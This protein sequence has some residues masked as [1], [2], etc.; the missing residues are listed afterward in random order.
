MCAWRAHLGPPLL[1]HMLGAVKPHTAVTHANIL[2]LVQVHMYIL[3]MYTFIRYTYPRRRQSAAWCR[4]APQW[5]WTVQQCR[6]QT[7]ARHCLRLAQ[8]QQLLRMV[9]SGVVLLHAMC[10]CSM[11]HSSTVVFLW[12]FP[13]SIQLPRTML[14]S[15]TIPAIPLHA[16]HTSRISTLYHM[17]THAHAHAIPFSTCQHTPTHAAGW[18]Q[19]CP[20]TAF[21]RA[22]AM[23][24]IG[25]TLNPV[26]SSP[27]QAFS[28]P[29][30]CCQSCAAQ[31]QCSAW[32]HLA[33]GASAV[34]CGSTCVLFTGTVML[35]PLPPDASYATI[36]LR[37]PR[38]VP[39]PDGIAVWMV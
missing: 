1:M 11:L 28:T 35:Q 17:L 9:R 6:T 15:S 21:G 37:Q 18:P 10:H 8:T 24:V 23:A 5:V 39:L 16:M 2:N 36:G 30:G 20:G 19:H 33:A 26:C 22:A 38:P 3:V 12:C 25:T 31:P 27:A 13:P 7:P 34:A 4:K 29:L 14:Q 32:M